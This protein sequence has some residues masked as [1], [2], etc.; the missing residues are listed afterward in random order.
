ME[1]MS[2]FFISKESPRNLFI[3]WQYFTLNMKKSDIARYHGISEPRVEQIC[4]RTEFKRRQAPKAFEK[5][6]EYAI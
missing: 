4:Y 6:L 2:C 5:A 3:W 1:K